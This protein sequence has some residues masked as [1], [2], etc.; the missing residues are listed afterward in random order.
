LDEALANARKVGFNYGV[1][2]NCG[3]GF[4]ITN[5]VLALEALKPL[6][7]H[8]NFVGMQA[9]G[10]EWVKMFSKETVAKFDYVF[11]DGMT[12]FDLN[13][14]RTRLWIKEE[15]QMGDKQQ[16]MDH[17]VKN[18]VTIL[19]NEPVD[20][21]VNPTFLPDVIAAEYDTLWTTER[22]QKVIDAAV[23]SGI[24]IEINS[25]YN[26]PSMTFLKMAKKAGAKFTFGTNNGDKNLGRNEYGLKVVKELDLKW[27]DM[28]S[29][30]PDGQKPIQ[31]RI[32]K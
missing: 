21:Y 27:Q 15:V 12:L 1:A 26:L 10:R 3:L 18:I 17:L 6:L 16:F 32:L 9:E 19:E 28:W 4:P 20:I 29:P 30:K 2:V 11:T 5:D 22:M 8:A 7:G 24:A 13:G 31:V 14:K 23:H 25:R